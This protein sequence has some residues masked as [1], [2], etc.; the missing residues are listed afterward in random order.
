MI[1]N[2]QIGYII[3]G[4]GRLY[5]AQKH[6][7]KSRRDIWESLDL[8]MPYQ[9]N[10][11]MSW[12]NHLKTSTSSNSMTWREKQFLLP[13]PTA[14]CRVKAL[15]VEKM[16]PLEILIGNPPGNQ[17]LGRPVLTSIAT[18]PG[19]KALTTSDALV[20]LGGGRWVWSRPPAVCQRGSADGSATLGKRNMT[21]GSLTNGGFNLKPPMFFFPIVVTFDHRRGAQNELGRRRVVSCGLRGGLGQ[22]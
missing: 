20:L 12:A 17:P 16:E 21:R 7:V 2:D 22:G 4:F 19:W 5:M 8:S 9:V 13:S 10:C 6:K 15:K 18:W 14:W 3:F 1:G 11:K